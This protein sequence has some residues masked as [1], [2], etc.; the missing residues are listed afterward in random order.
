MSP[1]L[2][3]DPIEDRLTCK[4]ARHL[5]FSDTSETDSRGRMAAPSGGTGFTATPP[6]ACRAA[7]SAV[8]S[9]WQ[10]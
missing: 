8:I 1:G 10:G 9:I 7:P 3:W 2:Q 4:P 6:T 5:D